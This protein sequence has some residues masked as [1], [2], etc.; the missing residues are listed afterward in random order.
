MRASRVTGETRPQVLQILTR[1]GAGGPPMAVVF[2]TRELN[3]MGYRTRL[4]TGRCDHVDLDMSYLLTPDDSVGWVSEMSRSVSLKS[5]L[6]ALWRLYRI[7]RKTRPIIVQTHTAK[8]GALGRIAAWLAGVPI[9]IHT[10]HGHVMSGYFSETVSVAIRTVERML[11]GITDAILVL[12]PQ[13]RTDL[14]DRFRI[15]SADRV[16]VMPLGLDLQPF[17][18]LAPPQRAD[19]LLT[20]GWLGRF[21]GVKNLSLLIQVMEETFRVNDRIRFLVAG[22]GTQR[23]LLEEATRRWG[24]DRL[25]WLGWVRDVSSVVAR[26]D[27]LIQTSKNEGTPVAL[28]QGMA[29]ARPFVSTRA[30]GVVDMVADLANRKSVDAQWFTNAVLVEPA[31][32]AFAAVLTELQQSSALLTEMGRAA[33]A[34]AA[35]R[36]GLELLARNYE[37][38][39]NRLSRQIGL[40]GEFGSMRSGL[41]SFP[42]HSEK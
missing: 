23:G 41:A 26:C 32:P 15:A 9:V 12:A 42:P 19:G 24:P 27:V 40:A 11:A 34:F 2:L 6:I 13:Q 4:I 7:I 14:V 22:D 31:A 21:V 17:Q 18:M 33:A 30:G 28:I 3:R 29:A 37:S 35:A 38:L 39:Y 16:I 1:L 36:Y 8:A 5:D 20:V 10:Y 25:Q